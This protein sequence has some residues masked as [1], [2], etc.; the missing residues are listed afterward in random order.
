[1]TERFLQIEQRHPH[2]RMDRNLRSAAAHLLGPDR[3][4]HIAAVQLD[5]A[6]AKPWLQRARE[7][8]QRAG[9]VERDTGV[10]RSQRDQPIERAAVQIMKS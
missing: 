1:M 2:R 5:A 10:V 3:F 4:G 6:V 9:A 8:R 7:L